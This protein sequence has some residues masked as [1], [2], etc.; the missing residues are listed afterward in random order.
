MS[1]VYPIAT[2]VENALA[3]GAPRVRT[4]REAENHGL[5][6]GKLEG[7]THDW[8]K[9]RQDDEGQLKEL[10][11]KGR[12]LGFVQSYEDAVN[13]DLVYA[14]TY[15]KVSGTVEDSNRSEKEEKE[16]PKPVSDNGN[17]FF[18]SVRKP[19]K[20]KKR[21]TETPDGRQLDLF[22]GPDQQGYERRDPNNP[23][24]ILAL[25]EGDGTSFGL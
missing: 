17:S 15:W 19:K 20:V 22:A 11:E 7:L 8:I 18:S 25:D 4:R 12:D 13:G 16:S 6:S 3:K 9:L 5:T 1:H 24:I 10:A 23:K 21:K 14:V 2:T